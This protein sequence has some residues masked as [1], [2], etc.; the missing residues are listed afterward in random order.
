M[1]GIYSLHC[2]GHSLSTD[3]CS[4]VPYTG[5]AT[6]SVPDHSHGISGSTSFLY[7]HLLDI[8]IFSRA[9]LPEIR[10]WFLLLFGTGS[11]ALQ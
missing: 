5:Q 4:A 7:F 1:A 2:P 11:S 8:R 3:S 10:F 6:D 9:A